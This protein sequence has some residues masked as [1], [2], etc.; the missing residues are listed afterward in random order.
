LLQ[1]RVAK[2]NSVVAVY[3]T[4][5]EAEAAVLALQSAG[6]NMKKLSIAG[7][8]YHTEDHAIGFYN[9]GDRMK[10]WGRRGAFCAK[11]K[12]IIDSTN[13]VSIEAHGESGPA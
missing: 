9:A 1:A 3:N 13:P 11:A 10:Y 5:P 7:K 4:H 8:D 6:F 2:I 12:R